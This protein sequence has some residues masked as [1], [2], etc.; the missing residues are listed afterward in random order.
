MKRS[1][2]KCYFD[3]IK[4]SF[5]LVFIRKFLSRYFKREFNQAILEYEEK[6]SFNHVKCFQM[7]N[8][9][10]FL[11]SFLSGILL[12]KNFKFVMINKALSPRLDTQ[13]MNFKETSLFMEVLLEKNYLVM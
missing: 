12:F 2:F 13:H 7:Y 11:I 8:E 5:D 10:D 1:I 9:S 6:L 4:I 3:I